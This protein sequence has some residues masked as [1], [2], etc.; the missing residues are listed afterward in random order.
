[1]RKS[2]YKPLNSSELISHF[3]IS[4]KNR[5]SFETLLEDLRF[6]GNL[7]KTKDNRYGVPE[8]MNLVVG[9]IR[10]SRKGF[11]FLLPLDK[12]QEDVYIH[13]TKA[14]NAMNDDLVAARIEKKP[15]KGKPEGMVVQI[16]RRSH[17]KLVGIFE[18]EGDHGWLIPE[19]SDICQ[20]I[21]IPKEE[22]LNAKNGQIV[23]AE[24]T[25]YP[26]H[27][28]NPEGRIEKILGFPNERF[29]ETKVA[30]EKYELPQEFSASAIQ[31]SMKYSY[32]DKREIMKRKNLRDLLTVTI[33][34]ENAKDFDDAISIEKT[35]KGNYKLWVH[36]ADVAH[37]VKKD[38]HLDKDAFL[39]G[40]SIYFP[41]L[42][43]PMLPERLSNDIC[44]L[45][46]NE[47]RLTV[48]VL[49]EFSSNG[50]K[51]NYELF[52]SIIS[53][54]ERMTYEDVKKILVDSD[55]KL[56]QKYSYLL[57]SFMNM[58]E[59]CLLLKEKRDNRGSLD[60]DLP[61]PR[62]IIDAT[63]NITNILKS[64]RNI[65]HQIIEEFMIAANETVAS[66]L[67]KKHIPSLYRVHEKPDSEKI[68]EFNEF[69][70]DL[71]YN[72][73]GIGQIMPKSLQNLL[74]QVKGTPVEH[75]IS[76]LLLRSL[77][78]AF[79]SKD[80]IGHFGLASKIYTHF[81]SPI[82]RYPDL[83]VHR[84]LKRML[85]S[86]NYSKNEMSELEKKLPVI[87][88]H[89]SE[90]EKVAEEAE[91]E[92]LAIKKL[93]FLYDK[94]G[95]TFAGIISGVTSFGIFVEISDLFIE[96]M[97]RLSSLNDDYYIFIE[98][99]HCLKGRRTKKTYRLGD[100]VKVKVIDVDLKRREVNLLF[101][102]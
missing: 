13:A 23:V 65:A 32:P 95:R 35:E 73:K 4:K 22:R 8:R 19:D 88:A 40:T 99:K 10:I 68:K 46:P 82:R 60:F 49:M 33:D 78:H 64:E 74:N 39:R 27:N 51:I 9:K 24:I 76:S 45:K 3:K 28:R 41:D 59:L 75:L 97:I 96:G 14:G 52:E 70:K 26:S 31:E 2:S 98:E 11:A 5:E 80:N 92:V 7:F 1:M 77:K 100:K 20:D 63:G 55:K 72:L 85:S 86:N 43:I 36:I 30:I 66:H 81:T 56:I 84:I 6:S 53:S 87:A 16:L 29:I 90:S 57:S 15:K 62:F 61:E 38:S 79:Y 101:A 91:R 21:F 25:R 94:K 67:F 48:S 69:I 50:E 34:G 44:S 37:Y 83:I 54:N 42:C 58:L 17:K 12:N 47:L 71:G 93:E 18:E 102:K 89:S